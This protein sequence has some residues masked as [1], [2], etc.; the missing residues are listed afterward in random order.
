MPVLE[1]KDKEKN[2]KKTLLIFACCF[3]LVASGAFA[4]GGAEQTAASATKGALMGTSGM[5]GSWYPVAAAVSNQ[6]SKYSDYILTIQASGGSGENIRLMKQKEYQLGM[7]NTVIINDAYHGTG[8]FKTEG[9]WTD[10]SFVCNL[11][12]TGM[13]AVV[14]KDSDIKSFADLKGK[15]VSPGSPGSGDLL[16]YEAVLNFYGLTIN[17]VDWRPLTHTERVTAMQDRQIDMAGYAT[18]WPS[19]SVIEMA[20]AREVRL[21]ALADPVKDKAEFIKQHP[22]YGTGIVKAGTYHG[23]DEDVEILTTGSIFVALPD[24]NADYVYNM[25]S[26]MYKGIDEVQSVHGMTK[27]ITE[28]TGADMRGDIPFHAGAE[29]YFKEKGIIK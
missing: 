5:T 12:P 10:V 1:R 26:C 25:L 2:M 7:V 29:R 3:M 13:Q 21:L 15:K 20:S 18:A 27:Y 9:A 22:A 14:W 16:Q 19:G 11:F 28:A 23:M 6:V 8:D 17:D 24:L 4:T